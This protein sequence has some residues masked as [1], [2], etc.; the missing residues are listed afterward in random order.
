MNA[1]KR[2]L[3]A[4]IAREGPMSVA[5][6][7]QACLT[8]PVHGY[9]VTRDPLGAEGDF[10]TAPEISQMFGEMIGLWLAQ[11]WMDQGSPNCV[12]AELG[13][14][15]G[16]LMAD[17]LRV[18]KGVPGFHDA[19]QIWLVEASPVLRAKQAEA[20]QG[21]APNWAREVSEL[22]QNLPLFVI[23]NEFFDALPIRQFTRHAGRWQERMIGGDDLLHFGLAPPMNMPV[24]DRRFPDVA[25]G[26][27]VEI[28]APSE[29]IA[30]TLA[31][32]IAE[33]GGAGLFIDYGDWDGVGD[34]LQALAAHEFADPLADP[35]QADLTAH[36]GFRWLAESGE[37]RHHFTAQGAFLERLGITARAEALAGTDFETIAKQHRR[38]TH[39]QEMGKL[40]KVLA[41]MPGAVPPPPG[42]DD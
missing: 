7:M 36:V 8:H 23:A 41:L 30:T 40:F 3:Q 15:R 6:F 38:L 4:Q 9:Y 33:N 10:T 25:E 28:S 26:Q 1:L 2:I 29:A 21:H 35:G 37:T 34:T 27:V 13:P 5:A 24:L 18:T 32:C 42:F 12:L 17:I 22:P 19:V 39:P 16:S 20:L 14:G 11:V 31:M